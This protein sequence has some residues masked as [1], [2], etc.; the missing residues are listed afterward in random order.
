MFIDQ[1]HKVYILFY[2]DDVLAIYH[3]DNER[4]A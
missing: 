2:V 4:K 3:K 1:E